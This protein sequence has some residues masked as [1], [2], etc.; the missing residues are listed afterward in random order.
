M[1]VGLLR[2]AMDHDAALEHG[3]RLLVDD[4]LE[5]L[6]ARGPGRHVFDRRGRVAVLL[7]AHHVGAV[8]VALGARAGE[9]DRDFVARQPGAG[10]QR[11][12]VVEGVRFEMDVLRRDVDGLGAFVLDPVVVQLGAFPDADLGAAVG[13]V[14]ARAEPDVVL[15]HRDAAARLEHDQVARVKGQRLR[16]GGA[17]VDDLD[18]Q[19]H[20]DAA[21][22][23]EHQ[24]VAHHRG[25]ERQQRLPVGLADPPQVLA[26]GLGVPAQRVRQAAELDA[27]G[28]LARHGEALHEPAVDEDH[29]VIDAALGQQ[30]RQMVDVDRVGGGRQEVGGLQ[31]AQARVLPGL[32]ARRRQAERGEAL[33]ARRA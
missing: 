24:P 25:I 8:E 4:A 12:G 3:A 6:A 23:P 30:G 33:D 29:P 21:L 27:L 22:D 9:A 10:G 28:P 11:E 19:R 17:H 20:R 7:A 5:D 31:R 1:A 32:D 14:G 16:P 2:A 18:R 13:E 15:D 26:D